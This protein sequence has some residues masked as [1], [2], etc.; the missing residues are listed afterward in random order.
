[1]TRD[2]LDYSDLPIEDTW[3]D[4]LRTRLPYSFSEI[5]KENSRRY[6]LSGPH[7]PSTTFAEYHNFW[8]RGHVYY[9]VGKLTDIQKLSLY[10]QNYH[11]SHTDP[12][13]NEYSG[14]VDL[15]A[16]S[17]PDVFNA[18]Q[19]EKLWAV[20]AADHLDRE[21]V[22]MTN[23]TQAIEFCLKAIKTHA[24]YRETGLFS[25]TE[26]HNLEEIYTSLPKKLQLE[27]RTESIT[28][29]D[30]YATFRKMIEDG[31]SRLGKR[32]LTTMGTPAG[33]QG[34]ARHFR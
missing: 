8:K 27:M 23:V 30:N 1:M 33:R 28:F 10:W 22:V 29:A 31:V 25:F 13:R 12:L 11:I 16:K 14:K 3:V 34:L 7:L 18:L 17:P 5:S 4:Y 15:L 2:V 32:R 21:R 24:E 26:G 19:L 9:A 6:I 20:V